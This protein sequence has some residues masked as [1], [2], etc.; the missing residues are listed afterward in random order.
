MSGEAFEM[1]PR[2]MPAFVVVEQVAED[3]E[4]VTED[5]S[6][7]DPTIEGALREAGW[8]VWADRHMALVA[9]MRAMA[10]V[11]RE[12]CYWRAGDGNKVDMDAALHEMLRDGR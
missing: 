7:G 9:E 2:G 3:L 12:L 10:R 8:D 6:P 5:A 11:Y 4:G 1:G